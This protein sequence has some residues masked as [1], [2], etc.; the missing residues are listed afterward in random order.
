MRIIETTKVQENGVGKERSSIRFPY[1]PIGDAIRVARTIFD[2]T[3]HGECEF[4][5]LASGLQMSTKSS[6]FRLLIS[7]A[8]M[9]GLITKSGSQSYKLTGLGTRIVDQDKQKAAK[10]EAFLLVPLFQKVYENY[11]GATLPPAS[12][13]ERE[14][15]LMGVAEKQKARARQVM[16]KSAEECGFFH[17][18]KDKLVKPAMQSLG[19]TEGMQKNHVDL[20]N[21]NN[22]RGTDGNSDSMKRGGGNGGGGDDNL[23]P[24]LKGLIARLPASGAHWPKS[25]R[26]KWVSILQSSFELIYEDEGY[27]DDE[28][29]VDDL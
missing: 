23:D 17:M 11:R 10:V 3:G 25:E 15:Q 20:G 19:N 29:N 13:I 24:I 7:T 26:K 28:Y 21:R 14:I 2:S 27:D 5:L 6:G 4:D 12:A 22:H 1:K 16:L 9:F 8:T 18:G